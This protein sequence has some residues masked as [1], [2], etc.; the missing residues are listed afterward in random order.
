MK[1]SSSYQHHRS[2]RPARNV[3]EARI[4]PPPP[5]I[6]APKRIRPGARLEGL[7]YEQQVVD[8]LLHR[9]EGR[10]LPGPWVEFVTGDELPRYCQPDGL[11]FDW[12]LGIIT[13]LEIKLKHT[14]AAYY[15]LLELYAPVLAKVF[16]ARLWE[17]RFCEVVK[18]Y[19]PATQFPGNH[20]L[21]EDLEECQRDVIGVHILGQRNINEYRRA[22][23]K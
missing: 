11:L 1:R 9:Y 15:Q 16:P 22:R 8:M 12:R 5:F 6:G 20:R 13:V 7:K 18:W 21:R 19:D 3:R 10:F 17:F 14:A 23:D 2:F 4:V